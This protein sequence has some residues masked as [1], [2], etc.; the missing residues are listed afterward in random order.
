MKI[1]FMFLLFLLSF[2]TE[3]IL[4][5]TG[6]KTFLNKKENITLNKQFIIDETLVKKEWVIRLMQENIK[7]ESSHFETIRSWIK[8]KLPILMEL[9]SGASWN[10]YQKLQT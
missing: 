1:Q 2:V 9:E 3:A 5:W 6:C 10:G 8:T 4:F 7:C